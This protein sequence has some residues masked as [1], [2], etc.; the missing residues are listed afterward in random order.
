MFTSKS[1]SLCHL[2]L[3]L[4]FAPI[5]VAEIYRWVDENGTVHFS[6]CP[7]AECRNQ[8]IGII[9]MPSEQ[10]IRDARARTERLKRFLSDI[11]SRREQT[12]DQDESAKSD[13]AS[14]RSPS[15]IR[16]F[17][18]LRESWEGRII[19][20]RENVDRKALTSGERAG[21]KRLFDALAR[22]SGGSVE[23][24]R[25]INPDASPPTETDDY[26][27]TLNAHWQPDDSLQMEALLTGTDGA[28][29]RR[30]F[31]WFLP[32]ADGL[33]FRKRNSS[34]WFEL[35]RPR[36]DVETLTVSDNELIFFLRRGGRLRQTEILSIQR[37]GA[38][39]RLSEY[40]YVQGHLA[41]KRHWMIDD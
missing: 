27:L 37:N 39:F 5:A 25:C 16:C 13:D 41:R 12:A 4:L 3:S 34:G 10:R 8:E 1:I 18:Q 35:D 14:P 6:D 11:D 21:V 20:N 23:E 29:N 31:Y 7:P 15:D 26:R 24:T 19:D 9:D 30:R 28:A 17:S 22:R 40:L 32:S 33:R 2:I 38:E 36:N